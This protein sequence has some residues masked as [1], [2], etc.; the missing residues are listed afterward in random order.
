M[1][2]YCF[3][4]KKTTALFGI[5][6]AALAGVG[7]LALYYWYMEQPQRHREIEEETEEEETTR[8]ARGKARADIADE[9]R[10]REQRRHPQQRRHPLVCLRQGLRHALEGLGFLRNL[11]FVRGSAVAFELACA[12]AVLAKK[13]S[14]YEFLRGH[15][16]PFKIL[17]AYVASNHLLYGVHSVMGTDK[18]PEAQNIAGIG[19]MLVTVRRG[20]WGGKKTKK[21]KKKNQKSLNR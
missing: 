13:G 7:G 8:E 19:A 1:V 3:G 18:R 12:A 6:L 15:T 5:P 21:P 11:R 9:R 17:V 4:D 20:G 10:R 14:V 2:P 16:T